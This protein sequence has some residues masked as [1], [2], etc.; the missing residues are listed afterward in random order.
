MRDISVVLN[1]TS[2]ENNCSVLEAFLLL[3]NEEKE[4]KDV[5]ILQSEPKQETS[6]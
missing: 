4:D 2:K 6:R 3:L 5:C 1:S